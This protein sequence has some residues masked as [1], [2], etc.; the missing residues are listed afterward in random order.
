MG[1]G[2]SPDVG[3]NEAVSRLRLLVLQGRHALAEGDE[4]PP[5]YQTSPGPKGQTCESC[6]F[7]ELFDDDSGAEG[8]CRAYDT[9]VTRAAWCSQWS[10]STRLDNPIPVPDDDP[11]PKTAAAPVAASPPVTSKKKK[12]SL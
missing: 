1:L 8:W 6:E 9:K 12:L 4:S 7:G 3:Q 2:K 11:T 5:D 10:K